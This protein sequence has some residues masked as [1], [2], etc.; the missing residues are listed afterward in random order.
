LP[1]P[2]IIAIV[3]C[4]YY[5][6]HSFL[7]YLYSAAPN[8][9]KPKS[10]GSPPYIYGGGGQALCSL[11]LVFRIKYYYLL[12]FLLLLYYYSYYYYYYYLLFILIIIY[13]LLLLF[14]IIIYYYYLYYYYY[15]YSSYSYSS[16]Y[17]NILV[18]P[19]FSCGSVRKTS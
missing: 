12:L 17:K 5:F 7:R 6:F 14:I 15:S 2:I 3:I 10:E 8:G 4:H 11:P 19:S 18:Y 16:Y 1:C 9:E 13:Y